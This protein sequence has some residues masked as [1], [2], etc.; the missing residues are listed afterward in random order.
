MDSDEKRNQNTPSFGADWLVPCCHLCNSD[1][2]LDTP[3]LSD[4]MVLHGFISDVRF[5]R[6]LAVVFSLK[7]R[8]GW[9]GE[10]S[11]FDGR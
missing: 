1:V 2:P 9:F 6:F 10:V 3:Q 11:L 4:L 5:I 7:L 8:L